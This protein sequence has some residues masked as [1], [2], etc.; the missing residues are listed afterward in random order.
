M[1][2]TN[3]LS[4][5]TVF[6]INDLSNSYNYHRSILPEHNNDLS[7]LFHKLLLHYNYSKFNS[8]IET[9]IMDIL[10]YYSSEVKDK[11]DAINK[12]LHKY[13]K[14]E[15]LYENKEFYNVIYKNR[16]CIGFTVLDVGPNSNGNDIQYIN[17][18]LVGRNYYSNK[19]ILSH[20]DHSYDKNI[21]LNIDKYLSYFFRDKYLSIYDLM[22]NFTS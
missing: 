15:I 19:S 9:G 4:L 11:F 14:Y 10:F 8:Y 12:F 1:K 2:Y 21:P 20:F 16:Y 18:D 13:L 6:P 5:M 3:N 17:V 7:L 22:I